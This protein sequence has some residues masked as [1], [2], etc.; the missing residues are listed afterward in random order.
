MALPLD[1]VGIDGAQE[2]HDW[3]GY[4]PTFHDAEI[5][6]LELNR[7]GSSLLSVH[8]WE[9]T[10]ETDQQG[11]YVLA[12]NITVDLLLDGIS[13]L[14]L[15]GFSHQNVVGGVSFER[16]GDGIMVTLWPCYGLSGSLEVS[17][18]SIRLRPGKP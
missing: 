10:N 16:K 7:S 11:Y 9:I 14:H 8:T 15:D 18:I 13:N 5:V 4:W 12:K 2:L 1:M 3:F 6:R 17:N